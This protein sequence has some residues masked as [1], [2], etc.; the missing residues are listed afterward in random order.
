MDSFGPNVVSLLLTS[1]SGQWYVVGAYVPPN[2]VPG[3]RRVVAPKGLEMILMGDL[4]AQ[5]SD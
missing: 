3:G 2:D 4:N 5:L 1:R